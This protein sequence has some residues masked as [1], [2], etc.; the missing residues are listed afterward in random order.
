MLAGQLGTEVGHGNTAPCSMAL[1]RLPTSGEIND[2]TASVIRSAL[3]D[4]GTDAP[5]NALSG[6]AWLRV[7]AQA[8]NDIN[9]FARIAAILHE[10]AREKVL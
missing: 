6:Q 10:A 8:Y 9:D 2:M 7:S 4:L 3:L 5:V 1:V